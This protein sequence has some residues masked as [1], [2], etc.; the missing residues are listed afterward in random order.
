MGSSLGFSVLFLFWVLDL[1]LHWRELT[2][3]ILRRY[4]GIF[5]VVEG[6]SKGDSG[7]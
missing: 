1:G 5:G 7:D 6:C 2:E 4:C 3:I